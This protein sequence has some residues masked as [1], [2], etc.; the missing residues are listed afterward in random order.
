MTLYIAFNYGG[1]DEMLDAAAGLAD[2]R[3]RR[4]RRR[5]RRAARRVSAADEALRRH[6]YAPEMHDPELLIR[7]SGEQR[8]SNFLLWQLAYSELYFSDKLWPDFAEATSTRRWP[9]T[10]GASAAS[11]ARVS[12][13][14]DGREGPR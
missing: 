11:G 12:G 7:T 4:G 6:L 14:G 3:G 13:S 10:P 5:G 2:E 8:I 9:S 1:R